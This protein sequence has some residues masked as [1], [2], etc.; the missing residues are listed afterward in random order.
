MG[1]RGALCE[2]KEIRNSN[3]S[4]SNVKNIINKINDFKNIKISA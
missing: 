1:F 4:I 2:N 3:I